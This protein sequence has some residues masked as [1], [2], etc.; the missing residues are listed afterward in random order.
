MHRLQ[1]CRGFYWR[2]WSLRLRMV[3]VALCVAVRGRTWPDGG[4]QTLQLTIGRLAQAGTLLVGVLVALIAMSQA[5]ICAHAGGRNRKSP[6]IRH[7]R[8][9]RL[10]H[11]KCF[12]LRKSLRDL[13]EVCV[14][15]FELRA[16]KARARVDKKICCGHCYSRQATA[17]CHVK[18]LAPNLRRNRQ[19]WKHA[20]KFA[21]NFLFAFSSGT[22]PE[23]KPDNGAP[24]RVA[25]F[26]RC[27]DTRTYHDTTACSKKVNP[28]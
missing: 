21:Q 20:F 19:F 26:K 11:D 23:L 7:R 22:V 16:I 14:V 18:S 5:S 28:R 1:C 15:M 2:Q 17:A 27:S 6:R 24:H 10:R 9:P 13:V 25:V 8:V 3:S 4:H 12:L